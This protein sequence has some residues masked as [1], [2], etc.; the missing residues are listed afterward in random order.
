MSNG[1]SGSTLISYIKNETLSNIE[2]SVE[3]RD[4]DMVASVG[5]ELHVLS[6]LA[7]PNALSRLEV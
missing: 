3:P 5:S 7:H 1:T 6:R 2:I 4:Y